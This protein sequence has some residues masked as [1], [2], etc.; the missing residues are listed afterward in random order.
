MS[1]HYLAPMFSPTTV[2]LIHAQDERGVSAMALY[3]NLLESGFVGELFPVGYV[4]PAK[5]AE[6]L[7]E[8]PDLAV[9]NV[10]AEHLFQILEA[11]NTRRVRS[12]VILSDLDAH[13]VSR[14]TAVRDLGELA[15]RAR[16]PIL[17]VGAGGLMR[18][19]LRLNASLAPHGGRAGSVAFVTPS[20]A[21]GTAMLDWLQGTE[22][23]LSCL[24]MTGENTWLSPG[25]VLDFLV[26]DRATECIML[27]L[28]QLPDARGFLSALRAAARIKPVIVLKS[29]RDD[30][31][32]VFDAALRRAGA[33]RVSSFG[34]LAAA[35]SALVSGTRPL[36]DG[37]GMLANGEG[38]LTLAR[39]RAAGLLPI[40]SAINVGNLAHAE[41]LK[42]ALQSLERD[43]TI[44]GSIV[45]LAP[46]VTMDMDAAAE[47]LAAHAQ[48]TGRPL[49]V[50]LLGDA[51][52]ASAR[53][54]LLAARVPCF[55]TAEAA[56]DGYIAM[57]TFY[58]NQQ[59]LLQTPESRSPQTEID[60]AGAHMLI[61]SVLTERRKILNE[62]ES[63]ALL[64]A[65]GVA[66]TQTMFVHSANEAILVA[67]Q[68]GFPVAMKVHSPD[69][70][71]KSDVGG[72]R[73]NV[74]NAL[75]VRNAYNDILAVVGE[76]L[77]E[78]RIEGIS[79]QPMSNKPNGRELAISVRQDD[80]FG[81][82]IRLGASG[83]MIEELQHAA[84]ALPPLNSFLASD[85]IRRSEI[86][87]ALGE[88]HGM[89]PI[90]ITALEQV[91]LKVSELICELPAIR[92]LDINPLIV[93]E[94]G[95]LAVDA[96]AVLHH[97]ARASADRYAHMA[98]SPYPSHLVKTIQLA[99]GADIV[100]RPI[101]PEDA[102]IEQ[103]FVRDL[104]DESKYFR[105][106]DT[107]NE[108]SQKMLIRFTQIDYD[109][110][111]AIIAVT[112]Q[113]GRELQIGVARYVMNPDGESVEF[114]LVVADEWQNRGLGSR[115]MLSLFD[116][117]RLRGF[118]IIEGDVLHNNR[119]MLKLMA[120]LGFTVAPSPDDPTIRRVIKM[121]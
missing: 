85:L 23:G 89:P 96:S 81:P 75:A 101:R 27:H 111:M 52:V 106:M 107:M 39:D 79:V 47:A 118:K 71:N 110:E 36:I 35:T 120:S 84:N 86:A 46:Q 94:N 67:E 17:G 7:P 3:K 68:L 99:D 19:H 66:V 22:M 31:D 4:D 55:R 62:M 104:S 34:A 44:G 20:T 43:P 90:E 69:I 28:E 113:E 112:Q 63:K 40:P 93:D 65:F 18:P 58:Q 25:A 61:E 105:F 121:L 60:P 87:P 56:V 11:C 80:I 114:A 30:G 82:V 98:I 103:R 59:M 10:P 49:I 5:V 73:L 91:L 51:R 48:T 83:A 26:G 57:V 8:R 15:R 72:V 41:D 95:A 109:R 78:A 74:A 88:F 12:A 42:T 2:A 50:C 24:V 54:T 100:L 16:L 77:P 29:C 53:R 14:A 37:V 92:D 116:A 119:G 108:L 97:P 45:T 102:E 21:L 6:K 13:P 64:A 33:V 9:I 76:R 32:A 38:L 1:Q 115:L 117:A 70:G